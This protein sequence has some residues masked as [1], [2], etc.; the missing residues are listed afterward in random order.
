MKDDSEEN[1]NNGGLDLSK[2]GINC[3]CCKNGKIHIIRKRKQQRNTIKLLL[4]L[5]NKIG[6]GRMETPDDGIF[7]PDTTHEIGNVEICDTGLVGIKSLQNKMKN[8]TD[9]SN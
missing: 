1:T 4:M 6:K 9:R 5:L 3:L 7:K 8:R 2:D